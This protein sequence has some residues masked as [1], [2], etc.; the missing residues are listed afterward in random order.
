MSDHRD[1]EERAEIYHSGIHPGLLSVEYRPKRWPRFWR[2]SFLP[3]VPIE[4]ARSGGDICR[5]IATSPDPV[6]VSRYG[7]VEACLMEF[8]GELGRAARSGQTGA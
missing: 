6:S 8:E 2:A 4:Y 5:E 1:F 7:V 3:D